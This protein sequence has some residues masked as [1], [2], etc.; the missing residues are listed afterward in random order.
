MNLVQN[1]FQK[2][3]NGL[4]TP[5]NTV[6]S[7]ETAGKNSNRRSIIR[8]CPILGISLV[9]IQVKMS[10]IGQIRIMDRRLLFSPGRFSTCNRV[11][12]GFQT[13]EIF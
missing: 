1:V 2:N 12:R 11:F 8:I 13:I 9:E 5:K 7:A 3:L 6:T 4:K 10:K